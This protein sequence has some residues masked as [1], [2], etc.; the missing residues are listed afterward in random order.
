MYLLRAIF[1]KMP[2]IGEKYIFDDDNEY[3]PFIAEN[4]QHIVEVY[5][6]K[7][8]WILFQYCNDFKCMD[9]LK[10]HTFRF[11]YKK[12]KGKSKNETR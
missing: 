8:K 7:G 5:D 6:V 1:G 3:N 9:S 11:C 4:D 10:V 12:I 2:K